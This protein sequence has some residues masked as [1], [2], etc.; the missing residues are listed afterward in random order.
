MFRIRSDPIRLPPVFINPSCAI[1]ISH[2][3]LSL[4]TYTYE[5]RNI[6]EESTNSYH[7][8]ISLANL[9]SVFLQ[10]L[11]E[12]LVLKVIQYE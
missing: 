8:A 3:L 7:L 5:H 10:L 6:A 1:V 9:L 12:G 2:I 4:F 11:H